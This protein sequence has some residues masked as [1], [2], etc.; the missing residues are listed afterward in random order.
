[1]FLGILRAA[2][3]ESE[4]GWSHLYAI[5][6]LLAWT[7]I[8]AILLLMM[9]I[10]LLPVILQVPQRISN[11]GGRR[12]LAFRTTSAGAV[13]G[14]ADGSESFYAWSDLV[15]A[16]RIWGLRF[17]FREGER[18]RRVYLLPRW[19]DAGRMSCLAA[20]V[21]REWLGIKSKRRRKRRVRR[22]R[23]LLING[24]RVT[25]RRSA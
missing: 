12:I 18:T 2:I 13:V 11:I 16:S 1:M 4:S 7:L 21:R 22:S 14:R 20:A 25:A 8:P 15:A 3:R 5:S 6:P 19:R 9:A 17:D 23:P 24:K 10:V